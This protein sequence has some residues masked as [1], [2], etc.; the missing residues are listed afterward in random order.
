MPIMRMQHEFGKIHEKED[1]CE[2]QIFL[3][4][5]KIAKTPSKKMIASLT[6]S[7]DRGRANMTNE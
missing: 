4:G 6:A 7:P 1:Y 2:L 5:P 3:Q